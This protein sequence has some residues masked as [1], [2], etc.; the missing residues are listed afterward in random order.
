MA[1]EDG[2][3]IKR[4][5]QSDACL[6]GMETLQR[7]L[8][9]LSFLSYH[10][11]VPTFVA[12]V[13]KPSRVFP[14]LSC[15]SNDISHPVSKAG[16]QNSARWRVFLHVRAWLCVRRRCYSHVLICG[17]KNIV[18]FSALII[19][20]YIYH[21]VQNIATMRL[22]TKNYNSISILNKA[23][24]NTEIINLLTTVVHNRSIKKRNFLVNSIQ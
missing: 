12:S 14:V 3:A 13:D 4:R 16:R 1:Y 9:L 23:S 20:I 2:R 11:Y 24:Q 10:G 15:S 19:Y 22:K 5:L 7:R 17:W 21:C 6:C 18:E 8:K